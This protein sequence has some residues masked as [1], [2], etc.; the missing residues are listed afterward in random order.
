MCKEPNLIENGEWVVHSQRFCISA[1][2]ERFFHGILRWFRI[3]HWYPIRIACNPHFGM[4]RI[5]WFHS[6]SEMRILSEKKP[7]LD[8]F[9]FLHYS[10]SIFCSV[11]TKPRNPI[12]LIISS[13]KEKSS[14]PTEYFWKVNSKRWDDSPIS[15]VV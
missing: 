2:F 14:G 15:S 6:I 7:K 12:L 5:E 4:Q 11:F 1:I 9:R 3:Q 10:G 8:K 13:I